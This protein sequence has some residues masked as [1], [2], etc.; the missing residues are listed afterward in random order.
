VFLIDISINSYDLGFY[1]YITS[2]ISYNLSQ[3]FNNYLQDYSTKKKIIP[4]FAFITYDSTSVQFYYI[5]SKTNEVKVNIM[6]SLNDPFCPVTR[7]KIFMKLSDNSQTLV[8]NQIEKIMEK[9][10]LYAEFKNKKIKELNSYEKSS[11]NSQDINQGSAIISAIY[12]AY[13]LVKNFNTK[14]CASKFFLFSSNKS[15]K[16]ILSIPEMDFNEF[17]S[18]DSEIKLFLPQHTLIVNLSK[19]FIEK[20]ITLNIFVLGDNSNYKEKLKQVHLP[21]FAGLSNN[22]GGNIFYYNLNYVN[23]NVNELKS[24]Y[25]KLHFDLNYILSTNFFTNV[26]FYLNSSTNLEAKAIFGP[27]DQKNNISTSNKTFSFSEINTD[28]NITYSINLRKN[29]KLSHNQKVHFQFVIYYTNPTDGFNYVRMINCSLTA[30]E[31]LKR[32][33]AYLNVD[34]MT[35]LILMKE[36]SSCLDLSNKNVCS[37][38]KIKGNLINRLVNILSFYKM[39]VSLEEKLDN[40]TLPFAIRYMPL[41]FDSF[42]KKPLMRKIKNKI[43]PNIIAYFINSIFSLP[44]NRLIKMLYPRMY[45]IDHIKKNLKKVKGKKEYMIVNDGLKRQD[46]E[47]LAEPIL[48]PLM[49][50]SWECDKVFLYDDGFYISLIISHKVNKSFLKEVKLIKNIH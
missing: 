38:E 30:T 18:T 27:F 2:S 37:F 40:L 5:D 16:G 7:E 1:E 8:F 34:C 28:F 26:K 9:I 48:C 22:T 41:Y 36:L 11:S 35:K 12:S 24:K 31:D 47:I 4:T 50:D 49:I 6:S 13:D 14:F 25:E 10:Q 44:L 33:F 39:D 23:N 3:V 43:H 17:Y 46:E 19:S 15:R 45:G 20:G 29:T 21:T 42:I 32:V